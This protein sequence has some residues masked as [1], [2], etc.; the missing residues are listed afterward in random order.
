ME[1]QWEESEKIL[2]CEEIKPGVYKCRVIEHRGTKL[3]SLE[4]LGEL[5]KSC[6]EVTWRNSGKSLKKS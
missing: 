1:H 6:P 3:V 2:S 5:K 4:R